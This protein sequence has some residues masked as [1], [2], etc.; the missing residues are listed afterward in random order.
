MNEE[1]YAFMYLQEESHWW[2]VGMRAIVL[3]LLPTSALPP[4]PRTL[5]AG[6]GTGYNLSWFKEQYGSKASGLDYYR[7]AFPFC[8]RRGEMDLVQGD[9]A[10]L[11]FVSGSFDLVASLD[12]LQQVPDEGARA[13][14]VMEFQRVLKPGGWFVIRVA[15]FEWLRSS[16]DNEL[17]TQR[18]FGAREFR[19]LIN[20]AGFQIVRFTFANSFLFPLAALWRCLKKIGLVP[21]GSDVRPTTRGTAWLND[22]MESLLRL[23]AAVLQKGA[24]SLPM[25]LSLIVVARKPVVG[26]Q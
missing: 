6:C 25:G 3:S 5:D 26:S 2:F 21:G 10:S 8:R 22:A 20:G 24:V 9:I 19:E 4:S 12:V 17:L 18:R 13:R 1:E 23:E 11:P 15:A 7:Y 16:H 14:A